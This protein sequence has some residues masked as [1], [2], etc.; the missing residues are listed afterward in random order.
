MDVTIKYRDILL[1][2]IDILNKPL[3]E[4]EQLVEILKRRLTKKEIKVLK[5]KEQNMDDVKIAENI[6]CDASRV[7]KLYKGL[8]KKLNQEKIKQELMVNETV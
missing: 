2:Y 8:V 1:G 7:D 3:K 5:A 4:E 6:N